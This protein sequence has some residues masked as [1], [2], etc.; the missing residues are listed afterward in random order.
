MNRFRRA[1]WMAAAIVVQIACTARHMQVAPAVTP[2]GVRFVIVDASA[3]SVAVAGS[4][5][6]WSSW[7]HPLQRDPRDG[8]WSAVIPLPPGEHQFMYVV[9]GSEFITPPLAERYADDGFGARNGVVVVG[10]EE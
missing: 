5:N 9:N 2:E 7:S 10:V 4:F 3:R 6:D 1:R 8:L